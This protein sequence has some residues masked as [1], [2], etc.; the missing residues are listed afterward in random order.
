MST[1][2]EETYPVELTAPDISSWRAGNTGIP[3]M[4][5]LDSGLPGSHAMVLA[6]THGN[7]LCGAIAVK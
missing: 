4:T 7:E 1:V 6:L 3:Y 5:T 2:T